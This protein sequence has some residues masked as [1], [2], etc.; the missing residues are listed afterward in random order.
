[1]L[2]QRYCPVRYTILPLLLA[3]LSACATEVDRGSGVA[4]VAPSTSPSVVPT[5]SESMPASTGAESAAATPL[6]AATEKTPSLHDIGNAI[7][8]QRGSA[9]LD[10]PAL[11]VLR[12]HA[13]HLRENSR[14][15]V[16][17]VG[18]TD[19]LGSR[20]FNLAIA[21]RR[22]AAVKAKLREFGVPARQIRE[23]SYGYEQPGA[24]CAGEPC[25]RKMRRVDLLYPKPRAERR[26]GEQKR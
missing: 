24:A 25:R 16:M 9:L 23:R 10:D 15:V 7:F 4:S 3:L 12:L 17:L 19:H 5:A 1:M 26:L 2:F 21:E 6:N 8:F 13:E 20:S 22:T 18:H 14:L 11:T